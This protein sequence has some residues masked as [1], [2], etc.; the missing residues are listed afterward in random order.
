MLT[1]LIVFFPLVLATYFSQKSSRI[2]FRS[3][4][5]GLSLGACISAFNVLFGSTYR[6]Y[7]AGF[8]NSFT[9]LFMR[10][11]F[12][13]LAFLSVILFFLSKDTLSFKVHAL[14]SYFSSFYV[15]YLPFRVLFRSSELTF[16]NLIAKPILFFF[17]L[18][19]C[20]S[21][22]TLLYREM[23]KTI[24]RKSFIALYSVLLVFFIVFP[25]CIE[26]LRCGET[27]LLWILFAVLYCALCVCFVLWGLKSDGGVQDYT[28]VPEAN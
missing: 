7:H 24:K 21:C 9:Y 2:Y 16:F 6:L 5:V 19:T 27:S 11:F 22:V 28:V 3:T 25:S 17:L 14:F 13:P 23:T 15:F 26:P 4:L 12:F 18:L 1:F 8:W 10:E 20:C